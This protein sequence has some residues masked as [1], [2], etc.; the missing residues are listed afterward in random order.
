[1]SRSIALIFALGLALGGSDAFAQRGVWDSRGEFFFQ[2]PL[3]PKFD[4]KL[5]K[6]LSPGEFWGRSQ[7]KGKI[8]LMRAVAPE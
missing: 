6:A 1:M 7:M 5:E 3:E 4:L 2:K 8:L